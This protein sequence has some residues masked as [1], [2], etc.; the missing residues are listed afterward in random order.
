MRIAV[1]HDYFTQLGGAERVAE[2]LYR[3]LPESALFATVA[4]PNC[5]PAQLKSVAVRTSWMQSMPKIHKYYRLYFLL[6]P[7]AVNSIDVSGYDLIV[8]SSSS[9]AKGVRTDYNSV[10]VCYC[11]TPMRW[12]WSYGG[13]SRRE[14]FGRLQRTL[15]P[16]LIRG[17]KH[18]DEGA[19]R[20][21]DHFVANS[22]VVAERILKAYGRRAEVIH[23]PIDT[24]RFRPS[25]EREDYYVLL[26]RLV[27]YKRI[28][29]A[30][31]ACTELSRKLLVIGDGPHRARLEAMAGPSIKFLGRA[32]DKDVEFHL[33]RCRALIF[34]G[35]EDFGMVPLEAGAAGRPTIAYRAGGAVE[36]VVENSTGVFFDEQTPEHLCEAIERF[37][38]M[39]WS[40]NA[41]RRHAENFS[42]EIFQ[43]RFRSFLRRIGM[44]VDSEGVRKQAVISGRAFARE[45]AS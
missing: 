10:H 18:W 39:E 15:L 23:P 27:S 11:H 14:S 17:L 25:R 29:L 36:T 35:E 4:L 24:D 12:V 32:A 33:S 8:S 37:E 38:Q 28:D 21:P 43:D 30:V 6:Y 19:S 31:Q 13:Y 5:M 42:V 1:V 34:P 22:K 41:I 2:E 44:P 26:S 16:V 45:R 20:Q 3:M 9:Y 40:S 7:L